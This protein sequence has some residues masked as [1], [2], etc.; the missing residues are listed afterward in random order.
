[1]EPGETMEQALRREIREELGDALEI[2]EVKPWAFRD[3]TRVKPTPT[4]PRKKFI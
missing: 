4:A 1:M 2:T 3:D